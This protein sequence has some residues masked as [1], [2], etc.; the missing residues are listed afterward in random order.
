[1]SNC[2]S[3]GN[4]I[5]AGH[6]TRLTQGNCIFKKPASGAKNDRV[7]HKK[8]LALAQECEIKAIPRLSRRGDSAQ[9]VVQNR[10]ASAAG[11]RVSEQTWPSFDLGSACADLS[12]GTCD[13]A[14]GRQFKQRPSDKKPKRGRFVGPDATSDSQKN[15]VM[16]IVKR[17]GC[18]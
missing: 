14:L 11:R 6:Q 7:E 17:E 5:S 16:E 15:T 13:E 1:M 9:D 12:W 2:A 10:M 4:A 18:S 8:A 3:T